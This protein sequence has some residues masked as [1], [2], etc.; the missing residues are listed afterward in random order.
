MNNPLLQSIIHGNIRLYLDR[1]TWINFRLTCRTFANFNRSDKDKLIEEYNSLPE[2]SSLIHV[3]INRK[4]QCKIGSFSICERG[5]FYHITPYQTKH[6]PACLRNQGSREIG[7][8][9]Y[10]QKHGFWLEIAKKN[11]VAMNHAILTRYHHGQMRERITFYHEYSNHV[12]DR[13]LIVMS[14]YTNLK[15]RG[16]LYTEFRGYIDYYDSCTWTRTSRTDSKIWQ[17]TTMT[18]G[19]LSLKICATGENNIEDKIHSIEFGV[20]N[21]MKERIGSWFKVH[22]RDVTVTKYD[23]GILY[24]GSTIY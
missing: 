14:D 9:H 23:Q 2:Y 15:N 8:F 10:G 21:E 1:E 22:L 3:G 13:R 16:D 24:D 11:N 12:D 4:Y 19:R 17:E 20:I 7:V 18:G 6:G 5:Y